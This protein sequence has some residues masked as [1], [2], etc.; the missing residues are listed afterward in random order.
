MFSFEGVDLELDLHVL[1]RYLLHDLFLVGRHLPF[2]F[3]LDHY[4]AFV[5][6]LIQELQRV[7]HLC[8]LV[9]SRPNAAIQVNEESPMLGALHLALHGSGQLRSAPRRVAGAEA[10]VIEAADDPS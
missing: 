7:H 4:I 8:V 5:F 1:L 10:I 3:R 2:I 9:L 6:A